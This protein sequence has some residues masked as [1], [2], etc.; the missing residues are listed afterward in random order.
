MIYIY[1]LT[2]S[3]TISAVQAFIAGAISYSYMP[4]NIAWRGVAHQVAQ[5]ALFG[6]VHH[7]F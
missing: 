5:V 7:L 2:A 4:A 3:Q 6:A 1:L